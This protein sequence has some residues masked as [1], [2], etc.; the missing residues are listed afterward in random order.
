MYISQAFLHFFRIEKRDYLYT[1]SHFLGAHLLKGLPG[2]YNF[3]R[4]VNNFSKQKNWWGHRQRASRDWLG[5]PPL[6]SRDSTPPMPRLNLLY[7]ASHRLLAELATQACAIQAFWRVVLPAVIFRGPMVEAVADLLV[8]Y[9]V[10]VDLA[11]AAVHRHLTC[12]PHGN[13]SWGLVGW[14]S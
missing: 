6:Q 7:P 8:V 1:S 12:N 3:S 9:L 4:Q 2:L 5:T 14:S 13:L 10:A 11:V